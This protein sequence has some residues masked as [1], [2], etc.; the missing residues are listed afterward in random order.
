MV[1]KEPEVCFEVSFE[2]GNKVGG[3]FTILKSKSGEMKN[4]YGDNYWT[5][6]FF[7]PKEYINNFEEKKIPEELEKIFSELEKEGIKCYYGRWFQANDVNLI[8]I[9]PKKFHEKKVTDIKKQFWEDYKIDSINVGFDFDEP[10]VWSYTVGMLIE[11]MLGMKGIKG[12]KSVAQ[13]HEWLS[14][15]G[16]LYLKEKNLPVGLVFT[17]HATRIGRAKSGCGENLMEEVNKGLEEGKY[18]DDQEAYKYELQ[19][20]HMM[21]LT[22]AKEADIFTTVS[23]IVKKEAKYILKRTPEVVAPNALDLTGAYRTRRLTILHEKYREKIDKFLEAYF[24]PY[25]PINMKDNMVIFVSGRYEYLNKGVDIYINALKDLNERLKKRNSKK[26]VFAFI[27]IPS[28]IKG[29]KSSILGNLVHYQKM[30]DLVKEKMVEVTDDIVSQMLYHKKIDMGEILDEEFLNDMKILSNF[31]MKHQGKNPPLCAYELDY[32]EK[33]DTII[34]ALQEASLT[35]KEEDKVKIIFYPTYLSPSDGLMG[36][37]YNEFVIGASVGVFPSRYEPWGYTPF[38]T[39]VLRTLSVTTDVAGFGK[40]IL[41][42]VPKENPIKVLHMMNNSN[43][44][45][46][47]EL[48]DILEYFVFM[49]K[50]D[51]TRLKIKTRETVDI[52][53]W[54]V[55]V[56]NY[57]KAHGLAVKKMKERVGKSG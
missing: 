32:D 28:G 26:L 34:K 31:F 54:K 40:F 42:N 22:T 25:Y 7:N 13:F 11:K 38:E 21:E 8:L 15:A 20:Q 24:S 44:N 29:P 12:K 45:V 19:A 6:G 51:K 39:A 36:L 16:L 3:I 1:E 57:F 49:K 48:A 27:L 17:T 50:E 10:I 53:D 43:N 35:N 33:E 41:K 30:R 23:D 4:K 2:C 56:V 37:D 47:K 14:G 9:D 5:I 55:Q 18:F 46:N 52:L